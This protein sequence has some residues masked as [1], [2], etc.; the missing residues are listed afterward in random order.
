[1][2]RNAE[3][4]LDDPLMAT[5][6]AEIDSANRPRAAIQADLKRKDAARKTLSKRY[7][8]AQCTAD[9][10]LDAVYSF[11]DNNT[12]LLFN[13]DPVERMIGYLK[14]YFT[15]KAEGEYSLAI[16]TGAQLPHVLCKCARML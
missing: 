9:E 3:A 1:M 15:P 13:R 16:S 2:E 11:S 7:A 14:Q 10:L 4:L 8:N 12:Y 5:A 6:T